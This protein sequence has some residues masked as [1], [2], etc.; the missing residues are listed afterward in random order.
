LV[1]I[2]GLKD[3]LIENFVTFLS[4]SGS[5]LMG[6]TEENLPKKNREFP[7]IRIN[8]IGQLKTNKKS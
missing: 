4:D 7:Q 3:L 5:K 1:A 8:Q 6:L 2:S